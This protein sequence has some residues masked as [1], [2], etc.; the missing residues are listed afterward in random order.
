[1]L[2]APG[3]ESVR[4]S[5]EVFLVDRIEHR[6]H[7]FLDDLVFQSGNPQGTLL[8]PRLRYEP[9]PDGQRPV[10]ATLDPCVQV[11]EVALQSRHIVLPRLAVDPGCSIALERHER[12]PQLVDRDVV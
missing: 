12:V 7:R 9:S 6:D 8:A 4:T 10:G 3:S 11:L 1:M 2:T 5:E